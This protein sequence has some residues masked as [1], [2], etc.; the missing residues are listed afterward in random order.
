[1][2]LSFFQSRITITISNACKLTITTK[3]ELFSSSIAS[4]S[5]KMLSNSFANGTNFVFRKRKLQQH[6]H[7][8]QR[9]QLQKQPQPQLQQPKPVHL[10]LLLLLALKQQMELKQ[11]M[12]NL[13]AHQKTQMIPK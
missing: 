10:H 12:D 4:L 3:F 8:Q 11:L 9:L 7:L 2:L 1:V 5:E 6:P 13:L